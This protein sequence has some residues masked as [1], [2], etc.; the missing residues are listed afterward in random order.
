MTKLAKLSK[1]G[2]S[3]K[4]TL[5]K[6]LCDILEWVEDQEIIIKMDDQGNIIIINSTLKDKKQ[7]RDHNNDF[8]S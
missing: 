5:P 1:I 2:G 8:F 3:F 6:Q 7:R 4:V